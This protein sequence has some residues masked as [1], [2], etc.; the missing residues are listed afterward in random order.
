MA[1]AWYITWLTNICSIDWQSYRLI[2]LNLEAFSYLINWGHICGSAIRL[3]FW[4]VKMMVRI[5][6]TCSFD[7]SSLKVF[8]VWCYSGLTHCL[9]SDSV[10]ALVFYFLWGRCLPVSAS[11]K[12]NPTVHIYWKKKKRL[13]LLV[14]YSDLFYS[15]KW[16]MSSCYVKDA[17][18]LS[19]GCPRVKWRMPSR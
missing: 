18:V 13:V 19:E 8:L 16:R 11:N 12:L 17:V 15:V 14:E 5:W 10:R 6:A 4:F 1:F 7:A 2:I 3:Y 9:D